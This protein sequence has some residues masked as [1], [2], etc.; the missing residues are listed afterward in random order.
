MQTKQDIERLLAGAG[1]KPNRRLGQNFLIDLNLM[2]LLVEAAGLTTQDT[3]LEV[4][5]PANL[6]VWDLNREVTITPDAFLSKGCSTPFTGWKVSGV[7]TLT[8]AD[9]HIMWQEVA[10]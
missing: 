10:R 7:C 1:L 3:A 6:C 5:K 2:K 9:G 8:I 4:G